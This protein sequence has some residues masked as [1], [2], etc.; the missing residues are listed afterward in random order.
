MSV[1]L[2]FICDDGFVMPTIVAITSAIL[3]KNEESV[4]NINVI[5]NNLSDYY[6][7]EFESLQTENVHI[8][9]IKL[10]KNFDEYP[11][12]NHN[13]I[14]P[15]SLIKFELANILSEIDKVIYVDGDTI[16]RKDL[17]ELY[18]TDILSC[19]SGV[20]KDII[21]II[22]NNILKE[23]DLDHEAYFNS[24][25]LLLNSKKIREDGIVDK[26]IDYRKNHKNIFMDQDA[27]NV[28]FE[29]NVKYLDIENDL[30]LSSL[31]HLDFNVLIDYYNLNNDITAQE[32]L[33]GATILHYASPEKPWKYKNSFNQKEWLFYYKKSILKEDK[34]EYVEDINE[35]NEYKETIRLM[36][37]DILEM[38][39]YIS[40]TKE[41][42]AGMKEYIAE[43]EEKNRN[44]I[45]VIEENI[46]TICWWFPFRKT[47]NAVRTL[48]RNMSYNQ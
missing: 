1:N 46:N 7:K 23:L 39:E 5:G 31:T 8:N 42:I 17:S 47:R 26:L 36:K 25:M 18:N 14:T 10:N 11:P 21:P 33:K 48:L 6:Y 28:V 2:V 19:Y 30:I 4:Y 24:G 40:K 35:A 12:A 34:L 32:L 20:V 29:E 37:E 9:V 45:P 43:L 41:D 38:K 22:H 16:I 44:R 27:F 15:T 13:P 3:N